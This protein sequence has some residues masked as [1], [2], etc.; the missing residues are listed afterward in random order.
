MG[1]SSRNENGYWFRAEIIL[2]L[3]L[4][5]FYRDCSNFGLKLI[6]M[7]LNVVSING[8]GPGLKLVPTSFSF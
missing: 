3:E 7:V 5:L 8:T 1:I 6:Y 2:S 4:E